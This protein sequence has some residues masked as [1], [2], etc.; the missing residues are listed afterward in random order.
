MWGWKTI[1]RKIKHKDFNSTVDRIVNLGFNK[2]ES[3][4]NFVLFY[5]D[6]LPLQLIPKG[7]N[8]SLQLALGKINN[9][10]IFMQLRYDTFVL[11]DTGDLE[12]YADI[13]ISKI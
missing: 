12:K 6:G 7:E 10:D 3:G 5:R 9:D 2:K 4:E 11:F 8:L 13:I 1:E